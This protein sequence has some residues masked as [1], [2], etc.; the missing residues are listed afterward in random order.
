MGNS[1]F[2][3][4]L[5]QLNLAMLLISTSG[6]LGRSIDLWPPVTIGIRAILAASLLYA[7]LRWKKIKLFIHSKDRLTILLGGILMGVHWVAYFQALRL[8]NV[9]IGMLTIYTYPTFTSILEPLVLKSKF[10]KVHLLLGLLV[11]FGISFLIPA[12]DFENEYTQAVGFGLLSA[13]AYAL[14]NILMKKQVENYH[15]SLLMWYQMIII[16][17]LLIPFGLSSNFNEVF[18]ELPFILLL[19]LVTTAIGHTLFLMTFKHFNITTASIISSTQPI[20]GILIGMMFLG[21]YPQWKTVLGGALILSAVVVESLR[22]MRK[23]KAASLE[24]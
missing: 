24:A 18:E 1:S 12:F 17:F 9:A 21:E 5:A 11:L 7:F 20:Y 4:N 19:A 13:I 22:E 6:V 14:R 3:K 23:A 15:G 16:G 8:S 2:L 10:Q